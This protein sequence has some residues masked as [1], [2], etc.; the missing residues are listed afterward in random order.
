M[1]D[2]NQQEA[3]LKS[4]IKKSNGIRV[5]SQLKILPHQP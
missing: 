2:L 1:T 3:T 5:I 4:Q